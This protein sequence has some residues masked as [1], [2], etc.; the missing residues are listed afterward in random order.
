MRMLWALWVN[1]GGM[2]YLVMASHATM[3]RLCF[4]CSQFH[5]YITTGSWEY[6][7]GSWWGSTPRITTACL[8]A[9]Q[10]ELLW[11]ELV[12][13]RVFGEE[14]RSSE[15]VWEKSCALAVELDS[16]VHREKRRVGSARGPGPWRDSAETVQ[17]NTS[18]G[19]VAT[20]DCEV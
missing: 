15:S 10:S 13:V 9:C 11:V 2:P 18:R 4:L 6:G 5:V 17:W 8:L 14:L 20:E 19:A 3:S 7:P 12:G 1:K 16:V